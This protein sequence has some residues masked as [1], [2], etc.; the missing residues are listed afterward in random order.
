VQLAQGYW[1]RPELTAERFIPNPFSLEAGARL[2]RTGDLGRYLAD[3]TIEYQGRID[4]QVKIR[5]FR[6]ELG[7]IESV[8]S[9]YPQVSQAVVLARPSDR[10]DHQLVAYIVP[11]P[12]IALSVAELRAFLR[13]KLPEYMVP[14]AFVELAALPLTPNGK[15]DRKALD[16]FAPL[17][18]ALEQVDQTPTTELEK[19]IASLW[20]D[21]LH[22]EKVGVHHNFFD[23]GG[24]SLLIVTLH[25]RLQKQ[26]QREFPLVAMFQYPTISALAGYLSQATRQLSSDRSSRNA[27]DRMTSTKRQK[28]IRQKHRKASNL[29]QL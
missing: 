15:L 19:T 12:A 20:Q 9:Q 11:H 7:E 29:K 13:E 26:I 8:L 23:I 22:L 28:Q 2:Y 21:A 17:R 3:G 16:T 14:A 1:Q 25:S 18:S 27:K 5:G 4:H 6:I 10:G 24:H